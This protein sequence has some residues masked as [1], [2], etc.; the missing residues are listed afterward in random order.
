LKLSIIIVDTNEL[1]FLRPC[2]T[3][4]FEQTKGID[5][6]VFVVDNASTD[7]S[8]ETIAKEFPLVKVVVNSEKKGFAAANNVALPKATGDYILLLNPDTE[9]LD[10]AIQKL[11]SWRV[12]RS[13]ELPDANSF[14]Q[15]V[16]FSRLFVRFRQC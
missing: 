15:I 3:S 13:L 6:E 12:I 11:R 14:I 9:V 8:R 2:L 16:Q 7:G 4:V 1:H 10:G 5:F